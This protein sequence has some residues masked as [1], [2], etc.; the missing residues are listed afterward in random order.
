MLGQQ[1][2]FLHGLPVPVIKIREADRSLISPLPRQLQQQPGTVWCRCR[3][4]GSHYSSR[5]ADIGS[6][7]TRCSPSLFTVLLYWQYTVPP[8]LVAWILRIRS[9]L[10][11]PT[12]IWRAHFRMDFQA[13]MDTCNSTCNGRPQYLL[14][15]SWALNPCL[16]IIN[17]R[18]LPSAHASSAH[19]S[20]SSSNQDGGVEDASAIGRA[21]RGNG[22]GPKEQCKVW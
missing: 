14:S 22:G 21:E 9:S 20:S 3:C 11:L 13:I 16:G 17:T 10:T 5:Y 1:H 6:I 18:Y 4:R 2:L 15:F 8:E 12:Q 7:I 19:P